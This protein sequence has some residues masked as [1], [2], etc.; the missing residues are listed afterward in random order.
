MH[1]GRF[2]TLVPSTGITIYIITIVNIDMWRILH[3]TF[4]LLSYIY[5]KLVP[6]YITPIMKGTRT[7]TRSTRRVLIIEKFVSVV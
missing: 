5:I 7:V 3:R 4:Q 2:W 6:S 1:L